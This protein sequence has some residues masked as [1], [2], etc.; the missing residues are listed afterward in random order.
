MNNFK[1]RISET[2][3]LLYDFIRNP[4]YKS[5]D[6]LDDDKSLVFL[7]SVLSGFTVIVRTLNQPDNFYEP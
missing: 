4:F 5:V 6:N 7:A 3:I 2:L 1:E